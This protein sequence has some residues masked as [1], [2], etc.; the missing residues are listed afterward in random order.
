MV[1]SVCSRSADYYTFFR[2]KN[3]KTACIQKQINHLILAQNLIYLPDMHITISDFKSQFDII[4]RDELQKIFEQVHG[5]IGS[6]PTKHYIDY[7]ATLALHGKRIRPY[8]TALAYTIY[9]NQD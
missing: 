9:S 3:K 1:I 4:F 5:H 7:I 8:N 6:H 2:P